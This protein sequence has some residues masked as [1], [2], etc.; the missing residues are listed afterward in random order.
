MRRPLVG[1]TLLYAAGVVLGRLWVPPLPWLFL[2][3]ATTLAAGLTRACRGPT[4]LALALV[5]AG[6]TNS[7]LHSITLSPHDLRC[8]TGEAAEYV[9]I[10]GR[11]VFTPEERY[12]SKGERQRSVAV[13]ETESLLIQEL[14]RR[15]VGRVIAT[16]PGRL[17]PE[18]FRGQRVVVTGVLRRPREVQAAELFDYRGYLSARGIH[19]ELRCESV[20]DW[21]LAGV[22]GARLSPPWSDRFQRWARRV[23]AQGLP[24]TDESVRLLWAMVLG[25]R[26]GLTDEVAEPF[27]HSGTMHIFAISGLHIGIITVILVAVC[28]A[29]RIPREW[30]W[31]VLIPALWFYTAATGWQASAVRATIMSS[32]VLAGWSLQRPL[33]LLNSLAGAAW[34]ILLWDPRQLFQV[35]FQLSFSVVLSI[36]L[37]LPHLARFQDWWMRSDRLRL[38]VEVSAW[39]RRWDGTVRR[40]VG[41]LGVSL[42]ATAGSIPW[43]AYYFNICTPVSLVANLAVVP[44][45]AVALMSSLGSLLTAAWCPYVSE[46]YNHSAWLAMNGMM[47]ASRWSADAPGAWFHVASPAGAVVAGYYVLLLAIAWDNRPFIKRGRLTALGVGAL[48]IAVGW[49]AGLPT[50]ELRLTILPLRGGDS[51]FVDMP[52]S[53]EDLLID[54]G[55]TSA[56]EQVVEPFLRA[57]GVNRLANL[58]LSHGDVR[59]M[60]GA[61]E[62]RKDFR[63]RQTVTSKVPARSTAYRELLRLLAD[64]PQA[65]RQAERGDEICGWRVLHPDSR[66]RFS[67]ADDSVLVLYREFGGVRILLCSDLS[68]AGQRTLTER[69]PGLSADIVVSGMPN[70]DEP[71]SD[72]FLRALAPGL[73]LISAGE[74]PATERPSRLLRERLGALGVPVL[75]SCDHG[76]LYLEV[77]DGTWHVRAQDGREE[78]GEVAAFD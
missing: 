23:L 54:T 18:Y 20:Q 64:S 50:A 39:K 65:W 70:P 31:A 19:H 41:S 38:E 46:L 51:L 76:A 11:L 28:R 29:I 68:R 2:A 43:M 45:S 16:T 71:L 4:M 69:E 73:I 55:D 52:G 35:G 6:W 53:S 58:V 30:C 12:D 17:R 10:R 33:D 21:S 63:V 3:T 15:A 14:D 26:T 13:I 78:Q 24:E 56:V 40:F 44:L 72:G 57:R 66:D 7:A 47:V 62:V 48:L 32:L 60:G 49:I 77:N 5:L 25:W 42:A 9:T 37:M 74:Y 27:R 36:V 61:M 75:F 59:H 67:R 34:L 1:V 22:V 8:V